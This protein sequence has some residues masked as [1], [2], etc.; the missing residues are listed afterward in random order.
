MIG[1]DSLLDKLAEYRRWLDELK[2]AQR[3]GAASVVVIK[4]QS[5]AAYDRSLS[6]AAGGVSSFSVTFTADVQDYPFATLDMIFYQDTVGSL[7]I[8]QVRVEE[9]LVSNPKVTTWDVTVN[10]PDDFN[11]HTFYVKEVVSAT[12]SGVI[13]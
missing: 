12:D 8:P 10:N 2:T 11:A 3:V 4:N 5:G 1:E 7:F 9:R 13:S 6:I